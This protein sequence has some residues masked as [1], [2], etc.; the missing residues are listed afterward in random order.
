MRRRGRSRDADAEA[1]LLG[2]D[3]ASIVSSRA[4]QSA[5]CRICRF[6]VTSSIGAPIRPVL[7]TVHPSALRTTGDLFSAD[8]NAAQKRRNSTPV[9]DGGASAHRQAGRS[10][11]PARRRG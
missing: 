9:G 3:V 2:A 10:R 8:L 6:R 4:F 1:E 5:S 11:P 7:E